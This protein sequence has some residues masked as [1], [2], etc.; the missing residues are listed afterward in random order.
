MGESFHLVKT[1]NPREFALRM[2]V[3]TRDMTPDLIPEIGTPLSEIPDIWKSRIPDAWRHYVFC[4]VGE[5]S[6]G[7][8]NFTFCAPK[9]DAER[10]EP[11]E[12]F[13]T[14]EE[15]PWPDVLVGNL[16][17]LEDINN[18]VQSVRPN[19][20][21]TEE[22][23]I[24]RIYVQ[25]KIK[26]G[27]TVDS[28][29]IVRRYQSDHTPFPESEI[30]HDEPIPGEI[31]WN[32]PGADQG[33]LVCLHEPQTIPGRFSPYVT[34]SGSTVGTVGGLIL[35]EQHIPRTN[36]KDWAPFI[37]RNRPTQTNGIWSREEVEIYP[38][39]GNKPV[40]F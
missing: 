33:R 35:Q 1:A 23:Y 39:V 7:F 37:L 18:P 4:E 24:P 22:V 31:Y 30:A 17:F 14:N 38:P 8:F 6:P 11:F 13:T 19:A 10:N 3:V 20:S 40:I 25:R 21:G 9:S 32:F 16:Q 34:V 27:I 2:D 36:F 26:R 29:C 28:L 5:S 12:V 15:Y